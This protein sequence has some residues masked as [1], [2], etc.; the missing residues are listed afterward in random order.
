MRTIVTGGAGFIGS[1][2][3][4]R[5]LADGHH[6]IA[7]DNFST[8]DPRFLESAKGAPHLEIV[9]LDVYEAP[10]LLREVVAG[11]D[12]VFHLSANADVRFGWDAP[13]R[14]LQQNVIATHNVL[15]AMRLTGVGRLVFS[16]TG[17][18]YGE[19]A[20]VPTREDAP[21]PTQTSLYGASKLGA[22]GYIQ[23]YAEGTGM[24]AT[25]FRFVSILGPRYTHGHI[26]DFMRKLQQNP[27]R[28]EILGDGTQRKSYLDVTDCVEALIMRGEVDHGCE[29][30]N[31]GTDS[32][33]TV[34][35]S[36]GWICE[37]LGVQPTFEY[38]GGDRGW[39][40]DNPYIH[41]DTS[42]IRATGW[43]PQ[44]TIRQGVE[45]TVD[46]LVENRWILDDQERGP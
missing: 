35:E 7:I 24:A 36:A 10:D 13:H 22:E 18:V 45:R 42:K 41:L 12:V 1:Q 31:L 37:R 39:I 30:F 3:T 8:G 43:Q 20:Q 15:E 34:T 6:A 17:S 16:S 28:L 2:V 19:T 33:C 23:A 27:D 40:G 21:F 14:D 38:T 32:H 9:E 25:I 26:V 29:I 11:S 5:L 4:E 46:Y 44:F